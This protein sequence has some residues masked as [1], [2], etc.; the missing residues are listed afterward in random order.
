M[1]EPYKPKHFLAYELVP[2]NVYKDRGEKSFQLLDNRALI[3]LDALRDAYGRITVNN[4]KWGGDRQWSGLRTPDSPYYSPYS[5]HTFGRAFDCIFSNTNAE[6][7]RQDILK[8]PDR[9]PFITFLEMDI[10]WLHFDTR[11]IDRITTWSPSR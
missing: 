8:N 7:V 1:I 9:F 6:I 3:T 10:S 11:N 2:P 4:Y 5:Q